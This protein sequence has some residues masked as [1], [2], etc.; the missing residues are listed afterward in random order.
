MGLIVNMV[1]VSY[2]SRYR[3]EWGVRTV[4]WIIPCDLNYYDAI[5]AFSSLKTIDWR[6]NNRY[7]VG[8]TV[9]VYASV[10]YQK[11]MFKTKV[12]AVDLMYEDT[13]DDFAFWK[14]PVDE[15]EKEKKK[16]RR[17]VKLQL[18]KFLECDDLG[19]EHLM[20]QGL[21]KAPQGAVKCQNDKLQLGEYIEK[22]FAQDTLDDK[23]NMI[24]ED[25]YYEGNSLEIQL[26]RYERNVEARKKC[27]EFHGCHCKICGFDFEEVYGEAGR[28]F[29]H[30]HHIVPL[31]EVKEEYSVN[32]K[33]D[34]I[35]VCPNC[36]AI[37]HRRKKPYTVQ[38][39]KQILRI[40]K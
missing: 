39:L 30:V 3:L 36:H 40:R 32:Y 24:E 12:L 35:P 34:L 8:D 13:I 19:L 15:R 16:S 11:I 28:G 4:Q 18:I 6:Q 25:N 37:I 1:T 29:I 33:K 20:E 38:E 21:Q 5:S 14:V 9:F 23:S 10:P 26:N 2:N 7:A 22:C 27:I 17:Y 31:S